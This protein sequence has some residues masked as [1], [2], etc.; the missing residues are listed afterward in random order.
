MMPPVLGLKTALPTRPHRRIGACA[1][2][3]IAATLSLPAVL[4]VAPAG[5]E[6]APEDIADRLVQ[7]VDGYVVAPE[8]SRTIT[9]EELGTIVGADLPDLAGRPADGY[10]RFFSTPAGDGMAVA[11][12]FDLGAGNAADFVAGFG[13]ATADRDDGVPLFPDAASPLGDVVA[14]DEADATS[15]RHGSVTAFASD[16]LVVVLVA[17]DPGDSLAVLRQMAQAQVALTPPTAAA[18]GPREDT[19]YKLGRLLALPVLVGGLVWLIVR[20]RRDP[21]HPAPAGQDQT[22]SPA[23]SPYPARR[24]GI[25]LPPL[26][27]RSEAPAP[28]PPP[29][30]PGI[31][32]PPLDP[33][34]ED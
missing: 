2:A 13:D 19:A 34:S 24:P 12:G 21:K 27:P 22:A 20:A 23:G 28:P 9:L 7:S 4:H 10:M 8:A 25:P 14:Y 30:R 5:A 32:L 1:V 26:E 3:M 17:G 18:A 29:R 15:S 11:L 16:S 6:E 33:G 31:P